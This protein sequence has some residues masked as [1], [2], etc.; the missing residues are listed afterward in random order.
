MFA[1]LIGEIRLWKFS[2]TGRGP[3]RRDRRADDMKGTPTLAQRAGAP[4]WLPLLIWRLQMMI[5]SNAIREWCIGDD[6]NGEPTELVTVRK[7]PERC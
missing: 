2:S 1:K 5:I 4:A 3:G 6:A 7:H